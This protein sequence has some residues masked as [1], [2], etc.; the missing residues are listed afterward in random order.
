[1]EGRLRRVCNRGPGG[2]VVLYGPRG[3][4]KTTLIGELFENARKMDAVA[5]TLLATRMRGGAGALTGVLDAGRKSGMGK[6]RKVEGG[7]HEFRLS[8]EFE[9]D[10]DETEVAIKPALESLLHKSS[11]VLIVDEAHEM[12]TESGTELL[13]TAQDLIMK[14]HRLLLVL[15]GTPGITTNLQTMRASFW[16]RC[17]RLRIGRLE[18]EEEVRKALAD[19]ARRR[20]RPIS[21]DALAL[22]VKESQRYPFFVQLL[23][24][25]VWEAATRAR[26][27]QGITLADATAGLVEV[28]EQRAEL[29]R[30]RYREAKRQRVL[31]EAKAVSRAIVASGKRARITDGELDRILAETAPSHG[32]SPDT[33]SEA[34]VRLGLIWE[35]L[36][37]EWEPGIPSL[38]GYFA[39]RADE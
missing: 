35:T 4:G 23:G 33:A 13:Q 16:E 15:A 30:D 9:K 29:Y 38:C 10:D 8:V 3:N 6:I 22:L 7:W 31:P 39:G 25:F 18:L 24:Y 32:S 36:D 28:N 11:V 2:G 27:F 26:N 21:D 37:G 20:G 14:K 1:M 19:P 12:P 34:L 5:C 17:T